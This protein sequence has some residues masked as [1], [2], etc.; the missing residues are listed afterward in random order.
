MSQEQR[1]TRRDVLK[2]AGLGGA[3]A[4]VLSGCGPTAKY[5]RRQ[6]YYD[7]PEYARPGASVYFA[8]TCRECPAG[9]GLVVR[10]VEGRAIKI[11][12]N[13]NH[14]VNKGATCARGQAALE[15][16]YNPDRAKGPTRQG[17]PITWDEAI[18]ALADLLQNTP[19]ESMAFLLGLAP[20][21]LAELVYEITQALGAP[22]PLRVGALAFMEARN[23]LAGAA[24]RVFGTKALPTFDI[25]DAD[26]VLS[27]GANFMETWLSPVYYGKAYGAMRRGRPGRRGILV[28]F[29]PR[30]SMTAANADLW[31]PIKPGTEGLVAQALGYLVAEAMGREPGEGLFQVDPAQI[32]QQA[33]VS[34]E[35]LEKVA[36]YIA[37]EAEKVVAIPGGVALGQSNGFAIAQAV[38]SL[39]ALF[40]E[41]GKETGVFF[42]PPVNGEAPLAPAT[43]ADIQDLIGRMQAGKVKV[44]FVHGVNP[45]YE[46][47]PS[48]GFAEAL[49]KVGTVVSFASFVD[50]T[51]AQAH[52]HLPDHTFLESWGYQ[53]V[54]VG[55]DR[56]T[57]SAFQPVV[58][59]VFDTKATADVLLAAVQQV[60]GALAEAVPYKNEVEFIQKKVAALR[61]RTDGIY[62]HPHPQVFWNLFLQHGGWWTEQSQ[63]ELARGSVLNVQVGEA[64]FDQGDLYLV[65]FPHPILAEGASAN[66]PWLQETPD[67][68]TTVMW[69]TWVE[70]HPETAARLGLQNDDVVEIA[71]PYGAIQAVVYVYP[72]IRPDTLAVP[73]GQGHTALGRWA[74][75]RGA[76]PLA[77]LGP[78]ANGASDPAFAR[79]RVRVR[80]LGTRR[81]LARKENVVG[82][83]G[84]GRYE[85]VEAKAESGMK[86]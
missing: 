32:A 74:R 36:R 57:L 51:A 7:M 40:Q 37:N 85:P 82:V 4:A 19:P 81:Q 59:P 64:D 78:E 2:L 1:L 86:E 33:E 56:E 28:H 13:P 72:G 6:P 54:Q 18:T 63:K 29:E 8:T 21:H 20:D 76:N 17:K 52:L 25:A 67:P 68:T 44:L 42:T 23:T 83:Y 34:L 39:N 53:R 75:G 46:F 65:V 22:P 66:N 84:D 80:R 62:A 58:V 50:E 5:V 47:P 31:L 12:G 43:L 27:F 14:P 45:V 49:K 71:S 11:E 55:A 3:V 30:M 26:L 48:W 60:G 70:V 79:V 24:E 41:L 38:L 69:N 35:K 77:L 10:T 61:E 73:M 15:T 16:L 9:C